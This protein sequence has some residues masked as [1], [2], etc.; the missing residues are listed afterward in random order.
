MT[1][2]HKIRPADDQLYA[3]LPSVNVSVHNSMPSELSRILPPN[4]IVRLEEQ[5]KLDPTLLMHLTGLQ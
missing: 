4:Y 2:E 3:G 1:S 5:L